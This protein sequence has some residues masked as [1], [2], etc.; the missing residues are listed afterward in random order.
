MPTVGTRSA[1]I[2]SLIRTTGIFKASLK[3]NCK[4]KYRNIEL[5]SRYNAK[6]Q[7]QLFKKK[8]EHFFSRRKIQVY[9]LWKML[10]EYEY[11]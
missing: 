11:E 8:A 2:T 4:L 9:I 5:D 6:T 10:H 1:T 7:K 3:N